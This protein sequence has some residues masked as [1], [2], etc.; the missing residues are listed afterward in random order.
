LG[1]A[2]DSIYEDVVGFYRGWHQL[3]MSGI[4]SDGHEIVD[5][6][7]CQL[8]RCD[9]FS[10]RRDVLDALV[11]LRRRLGGQTNPDRTVQDNLSA[12]DTYLRAV[13]GER[14]SLSRYVA[15]L[16]LYDPVPIA[17]QILDATFAE[18]RELCL[19]FGL[20]YRSEDRAAYLARFGV[21][22]ATEVAQLARA[23]QDYW[24]ERL[25]KH[26]EPPP[27]LKI[28]VQIVQEDE[29]WSFFLNA[30]MG[31]AIFS[32]NAHPRHV[33]TRGQCQYITSHEIA[34]HAVQNSCWAQAVTRDDLPAALLI[35]ATHHPI[36]PLGEGM[37]QA[38][39]YFLCLNAEVGR[40]MMLAKKLR[41]LRDMALA[42]AQLMLEGGGSVSA[43]WEYCTS[44]LYFVEPFE[45]ERDLAD[46]A[47]KPAERA[48][49]NCY[50]P[51]FLA[52]RRIAGRLSQD[53]VGDFLRSHY[54]QIPS[55]REFWRRA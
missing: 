10:S 16:Y 25:Y 54:H 20:S 11:R 4:Y 46:R 42:N 51:S 21:E 26:V 53:E 18:V 37:A 6:D 50:A 40:E 55:V 43:A 44:R 39:P 45:I 49:Q 24:L 36:A 1:A 8:S 31:L 28:D 14:M 48:Y 22:S 30:R 19:D 32:I 29:P 9:S 41:E 23:G 52:F 38:L 47:L 7:Y 12:S 35:H 27:N 17:E 3:E 33:F 2:L 13:L 5:Q 34:G 15:A